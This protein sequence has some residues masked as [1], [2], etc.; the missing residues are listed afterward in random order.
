MCNVILCYD[1]GNRGRNKAIKMIV[2]RKK[3]DE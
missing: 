3:G 1:E 2:T